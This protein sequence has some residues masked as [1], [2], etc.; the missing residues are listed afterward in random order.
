[1]LWRC[2][3]HP[4]AVNTSVWLAS[5]F[6]SLYLRT[7][8]F[9]G[10]IPCTRNIVRMSSEVL[11]LCFC[12]IVFASPGWRIP[13]DSEHGMRF[14]RS[15]GEFKAPKHR[16]QPSWSF[17]CLISTHGHLKWCKPTCPHILWFP[18]TGL[19]LSLISTAIA[20]WN[21]VTIR[22]HHGV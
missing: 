18:C 4:D 12:D 9:Q 22:R 3:F 7:P 17:H 1:M 5:M 14:R 19:D 16:V 15:S 6:L 8:A 11:E 21:W 2:W 10:R 13:T 20:V